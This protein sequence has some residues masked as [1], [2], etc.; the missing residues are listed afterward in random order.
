MYSLIEYI[1]NCSGMTVSWLF[2][3]KNEATNC[4]FDIA[5]TDDFKS[6]RYKAKFLENIEA[7]EVN[8]V[9]R[10]AAISVPSKYLGNFCRSLE[11]LLINYKVKRTK[12]W[13]LSVLG[14]DNDDTN[15]NNIFTIKD[16]KL[17]VPVV[18]LLANGNQKLSK[19]LIKGF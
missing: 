1:S 12:H 8:E 7:G 14:V 2:Y 16:T 4:N 13:V 6:F 3:S 11:I 15:P 10:N 17:Y 19:L 9:F 5:N 18:T